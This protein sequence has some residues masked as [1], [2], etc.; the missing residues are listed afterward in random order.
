MTASKVS[1]NNLGVFHESHWSLSPILIVMKIH[2]PL[3]LSSHKF[4]TACQN[5]S[6]EKFIAW[7]LG[8]FH[9]FSLILNTSTLS[10]FEEIFGAGLFHDFLLIYV[11]N[12]SSPSFFYLAPKCHS[13]RTL[14]HCPELIKFTVRINFSIVC[15]YLKL[16]FFGPNSSIL[17][18]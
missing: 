12:L 7:V 15:T 3:D 8:R 6:R 17:L 2:I 4:K 5:W 14:Y 11:Q 18:A 16:S 9:N 1:H 13:F 10:E